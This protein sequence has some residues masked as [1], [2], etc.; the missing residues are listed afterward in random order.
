MNILGIDP[1]INGTG[2][3]LYDS[4]TQIYSMWVVEKYHA[5]KGNYPFEL[6]YQRPTGKSKKAV[7]IINL[8]NNTYNM[9]EFLKTINFD[10]VYMEG[11]AGKATTNC[12][13]A[14]GFFC[15]TLKMLLVELSIPYKLIPPKRLKKI[16]T[17]NGNASKEDMIRRV[18]DKYDTVLAALNNIKQLPP[19]VSKAFD[20]HMSTLGVPS[21]YDP[22]DDLCDAMH[23][24]NIGIL[25]Q[26]L[27]PYNALAPAGS[28]F[29]EI[30]HSKFIKGMTE[31]SL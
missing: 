13:T 2:L 30:H 6:V 14:L 15:E 22:A 25:D 19:E 1:S 17:N 8:R 20:D 29:L 27:F 5:K 31:V 4:K 3:C 24:A 7:T 9:L 12:L 28:Q 16:V 11:Y 21:S 23:L 18:I 26:G 10:V